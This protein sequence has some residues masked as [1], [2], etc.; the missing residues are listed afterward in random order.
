MA[1]AALAIG[2][3]GYLTYA[4]IAA[5]Q[6]SCGCLGASHAPVSWRSFARAGVLLLAALAAAVA[7]TAWWSAIRTARVD[8]VLA[9]EAAMFVALS[10]ELDQYWL[11]PLRKMRARL[12]NPLAGAPDVVPLHATVTQLQR[13]EAYRRVAALLA[14][15]VREHW[16]ADE[17][18][19]RCYAARY[20]DRPATAVFAVPLLREDPAAVW[21]SF[22]NE[23]A[24]LSEPALHSN[25]QTLASSQ[26][27]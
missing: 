3:M 25:S 27:P 23:E 14:S 22:V 18:R 10:P 2:F 26:H 17:W 13:S 11:V 15:D 7:G 6:A 1:A 19:I 16:D 21:V 12:T 8:A 20:Q 24:A 5:P 9:A 4:V